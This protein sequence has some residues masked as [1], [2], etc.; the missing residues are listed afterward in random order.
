MMLPLKCPICICAGCCQ[1]HFSL[2]WMLCITVA[3][4]I[5]SKGQ[6]KDVQ[7]FTGIEN[8]TSLP[9]LCARRCPTKSLFLVTSSLLPSSWCCSKH[10][11]CA[12]SKSSPDA[13]WNHWKYSCQL[14]V[15][16]FP[17]YISRG[18][19]LWISDFV[20]YPAYFQ[21]FFFLNYFLRDVLEETL[22]PACKPKQLWRIILFTRSCPY[23]IQFKSQLFSPISSI[24]STT[25]WKK[26]MTCFSDMAEAV[27]PQNVEH[28]NVTWSVYT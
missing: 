25:F 2:L 5:T 17:Q 15:F 6:R 28:K 4:K 14:R 1:P 27:Y 24:R 21:L 12:S 23:F 8:S 19:S 3:W 16:S 22:Y 26:M 10:V 20:Y 13:W 18:C 9:M 11:P 7:M